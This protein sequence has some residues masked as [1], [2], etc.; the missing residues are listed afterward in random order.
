MRHNEKKTYMHTY[1]IQRFLFCSLSYV[2]WCSAISKKCH[3]QGVINFIL[4]HI[5]QVHLLAVV[6]S[7]LEA[8]I[9]LS[10]TSQGQ[11]ILCWLC[12]WEIISGR[13]LVCTVFW[14]ILT[15]LTLG[16]C[17]LAYFFIPNPTPAWHEQQ[18]SMGQDGTLSSTSFSFAICSN[19]QMLKKTICVP[20]F[21]VCTEVFLFWNSCARGLF[22]PFI[23][24]FNPGG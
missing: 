21:R 10:L 6:N 16:G 24:V 5:S 22:F 23:V 18:V 19:E 4:H 15:S 17:S 9:Q 3:L 20:V 12:L 8:I 13:I 11:D 7:Y 1:K 2:V 14:S